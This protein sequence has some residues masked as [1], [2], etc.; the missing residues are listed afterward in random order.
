MA[1]KRK[2]FPHISSGEDVDHSFHDCYGIS[3]RQSDCL[4]VRTDANV[5][6]GGEKPGYSTT[7]GIQFWVEI[8]SS[9]DEQLNEARQ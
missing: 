8:A 7:T 6:L 3:K 2:Q 4:V 5:R 9:L 1:T